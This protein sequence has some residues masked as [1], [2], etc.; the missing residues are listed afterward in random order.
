MKYLL[1]VA[2]SARMLA[3]AAKK[4]GF[5]VLVIDLYADLDTQGY[6][7]DYRQ[8]ESLAEHDL[9]AAVDYFIERYAV[10]HL[11]YGS[12]FECCPESLYYLSSRL[13]ILGNHPDVFARQLDKQAFFSTLDDLN[14]RH[15]DVVF[16][17]PGCTEDW[18]VKPMRGQGGFGIERY[19]DGDQ[20]KPSDYWQKFQAGTPHSALF[21]ADGQNMHV[22]GFN[23]QWCVRVSESQEFI[24][25]GLMNHAELPDQH[26]KEITGWLEQMVPAFGL[27]GINS[28]DFIHADDGSYVLE[29][30][31]RPSASM[32]LYAGDLLAKHIQV[33]SEGASVDRRLDVMRLKP[34]PQRAYQIIYAEHDTLIPDHFE[35]PE[36]CADLP[37][38][39]NICRTGQPIC[40]I[41][42]RQKNLQSVV[43]IL[44]AKQQFIINKLERF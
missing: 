14:V 5:K 23:I 8:V 30:N 16:S 39:G 4:S 33:C 20:V 22:V 26:K 42:A 3:Q 17:A 24:F 2:G 15:P 25:S 37:E 27:K 1:V 38:P 18:L 9:S 28:L 31:P 35:W 19:R 32:Q 10:S 6:A 11:V 21:L 7:D 29:I 40:S 13:N 41:I 44:R 43:E 12:G 36:W 34:V